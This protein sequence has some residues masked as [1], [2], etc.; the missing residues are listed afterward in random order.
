M[1]DPLGF[2]VE[3]VHSLDFTSRYFWLS[4]IFIAGSPIGW[5][6]LGRVE[7]YT[8]FFTK[9]FGSKF[10]GCYVLAAYIWIWSAFRDYFFACA[11]DEQPSL[12][13]S[14]PFALL[15]QLA[16][17]ICYVVGA[18]FVLS[19]M[20]VL[21]ILGTYNGDY[22]RILME[23]RITH[24]PF[25]VVNNPMYNGSTLCFLGHALIYQ[26]PIGIVLSG[27][28]FFMY[29]IGVIFEEPFTSYIYSQAA[30]EKEEEEKRV[31]LE[32]MA[33]S[34]VNA[35]IN[36]DGTIN[37]SA[38]LSDNVKVEDW[39]I[40]GVSEWLDKRVGL[41]Q[42]VDNF[43]NN[44]IDGS[45]LCRLDL[46]MLKNDVNIPSLGHRYRI[47]DAYKQQ[48][49]DN[50]ARLPNK[51][52]SERKAIESKIKEVVA[53]A[54]KERLGGITI[55]AEAGEDETFKVP[56]ATRASGSQSSDSEDDKKKN[57]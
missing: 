51:W 34:A 10:V 11:V 27:W 46:N 22:F 8:R 2:V 21:G 57:N 16:G 19:S 9:L 26:S 52:I 41:G 29:R 45:V 50:V 53:S 56:K 35:S 54:V 14:L 55:F 5:N 18:I 4:V 37:E 3:F 48:L 38:L 6:I 20:W 33:V 13:L 44:H 1:V 25:N 36:P 40:D 23:E 17:I 47:L 7:Y 32:K 30:I 49:H 42:Y 39:T 15:F 12:T 24:F 28:V 31:A 43:K